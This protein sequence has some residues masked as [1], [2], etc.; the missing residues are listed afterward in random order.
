[1]LVSQMWA[2]VST[3]RSSAHRG[4]LGGERGD[5]HPLVHQ[6]QRRREVVGR[7]G[8]RRRAAVALGLDQRGGVVDPLLHERR[9]QLARSRRWWPA[10][11][12]RRSATARCAPN[13]SK[14][15]LMPS[16]QTRGA[17]RRAV[18]RRAPSRRRVRL[19]RSPGRAASAAPR[20]WTGN[21]SRTSGRDMPAPLA[22]SS[23]EISANGRSSSRRSAVAR[24]A[25]SRSSPDGRVGAAAAAR[26]RG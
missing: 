11:R 2:S 7:D 18:A 19:A 5:H 16:R 1:M 4:S 22:R 24:I 26:M 17:G 3:T 23:T 20:P 14:K 8:V 13:A 12:H 10:P 25:A 9:P 21:R 15:A 6:V